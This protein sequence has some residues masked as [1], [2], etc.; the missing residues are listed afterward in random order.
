MQNGQE[1]FQILDLGCSLYELLVDG[2]MIFLHWSSE[3]VV[4]DCCSASAQAGREA[5]VSTGLIV[6]AWNKHEW[7][8]ES[9]LF[10]LRK[11]IKA[12]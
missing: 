9:I 3:C 1:I 8:S 2:Q 5:I 11:D 7:T 6:I 10:Q 12:D 4:T